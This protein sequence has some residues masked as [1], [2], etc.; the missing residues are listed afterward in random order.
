MS[1]QIFLM[2]PM[3]QWS[4]KRPHFQKLEEDTLEKFATSETST[5]P[6]QFQLL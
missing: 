1:K 3:G 6:Y 5:A 4:Q 2:P